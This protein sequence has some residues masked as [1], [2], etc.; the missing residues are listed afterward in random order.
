MATAYI[1]RYGSANA[2]TGPFSSNG[3]GDEVG[4]EFS[5]LCEAW[6]VNGGGSMKVVDCV[7]VETTDSGRKGISSAAEDVSIVI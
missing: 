6:F 5:P 7:A 4:L 3:A 2:E 1:I